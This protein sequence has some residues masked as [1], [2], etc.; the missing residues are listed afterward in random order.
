MGASLIGGALLSSASG[1]VLWV[2]ETPE[3]IEREGM[4]KTAAPEP[5]RDDSWYN[6]SIL[7]PVFGDFERAEAR[8]LVDATE[9]FELATRGKYLAESV[10][11][12]GSC[13]GA[14]S[15]DSKLG[16]GYSAPQAPLSGGR[17]MQDRFGAVRAANI[18]PDK[19]SGIGNWNTT[20]IVRAIRAS[21]D[22]DGRPLSIDHHRQYR[23]MADKDAQAI[24]LYLRTLEPVRSVVERRRLGGIQRNRWGLISNHKDFEGYVPLPNE[25]DRANYGGYLATNVAGC[26]GCHSPQGGLLDSAIPFAGSEQ[27]G[28]SLFGSLKALFTALQPDSEAEVRAKREQSLKGLLSEDAQRE[29]VARGEIDAPGRPR[30]TAAGKVGSSVGANPKYDEL[31]VDGELPA[32]G[33]DI[34]GTAQSGLLEWNTKAII[35][36]LQSGL[37]PTGEQRDGRVCPWPYFRGMS[38]RDKEAIALFL[39]RQ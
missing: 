6:T 16:V 19:T 22:R 14:V 32:G 36:Y 12:C 20:D 31:I 4:A 17:L 11:A 2:T 37:T 10:A 1:C 9:R 13:H 26:Y 33:P 5:Q 7:S 38:E 15:R 23:W 29:L 39:K 3:S 28:R 30:A 21:I 35:Q 27:Q 18:T 34:R 24:A 25:A 8:E